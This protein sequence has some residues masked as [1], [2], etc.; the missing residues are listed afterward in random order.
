MILIMI[1]LNGNAKDDLITFNWGSDPITI[2][3]YNLAKDILYTI[4]EIEYLKNLLSYKNLYEDI[5]KLNE[6]YEKKI[7]K[8]NIKDIQIKILLFTT[9][10][11]GICFVGI[12]S[13][14]ITY[15]IL[16]NTYRY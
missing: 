12:L 2:T 8:I 16:I 10:F 9:C 3:K 1:T 5:N 4:V 7:D 13:G 14:V 6:Y 11:F 15:A